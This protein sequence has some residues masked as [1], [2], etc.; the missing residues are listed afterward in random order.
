[1]EQQQQLRE[2]ITRLHAGVCK[3]LADPNRI[4]LL[5]TLAESPHTVN[6]L[7]ATVGLPQSTVSRHL[8]TL[9]EQRMVVTERQGPSVTYTLADQ[10]V[11]EAL[12]LLRAFMADT[13]Q[14]QSEL[15]QTAID[16]LTP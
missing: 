12:E 5:Y 13:L 8:K 9:R 10:R 7:A 2:E 6:D 11:I 3:G 1:M 4:L 16:S 14:S 15:A